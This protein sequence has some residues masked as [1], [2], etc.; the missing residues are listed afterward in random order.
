MT[1]V[2]AT[3]VPVAPSS[4]VNLKWG[5]RQGRWGLPR[6]PISSEG[7]VGFQWMVLGTRTK[8]LPHGPRSQPETWVTGK[9]DIYVFR[10]TSPIQ[11]FSDHFWPDEVDSR[12]LLYPYRFGVEKVALGTQLRNSFDDPIPKEISN[13]VRVAAGGGPN[14]VHV[15]DDEMRGLIEH[16][17]GKV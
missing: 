7:G 12:Q 3:Y 11:E 10:A 15:T 6:L 1:A 9:T 5:L 8:G 2:L 4:Q 14:I 16:L 17:G 13:G